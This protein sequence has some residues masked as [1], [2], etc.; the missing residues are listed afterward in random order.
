MKRWNVISI[1][2]VIV[3]AIGL[4]AMYFM[5]AENDTIINLNK[6]V[7]GKNISINISKGQQYLHKFKVNSL[8]HIKTPPQ[9]AIWVEDTSGNYIKT[10]YATEKIVEQKW[11]AS[12]PGEI[13]RKEALPYWTHKKGND[14]NLDMV[15]SATPKGNSLIHTTFD[16]NNDEYVIL[17]EVNMSTDFNEFYP[18]DAK[19]GESNYSGGNNGSGQPALIYSAKVNNSDLETN[20]YELEL[21]GHSSADGS[22]GELFTDMEGITTAKDIIDKIEITLGD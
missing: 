17:A 22:N 3:L 13:V 19:L 9:V 10:L 12:K 18:R 7:N 20:H 16:S 21:V 6:N 4:T 1:F 8:I 14:T 15:S 11:G 2:S 5:K